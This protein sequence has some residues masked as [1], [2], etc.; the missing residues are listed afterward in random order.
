MEMD[1]NY[2]PLAPIRLYRANGLVIPFGLGASTD[3]QRGTALMQADA[4]SVAAGTTAT[5]KIVLAGDGFDTGATRPALSITSLFGAGIGKT[6]LTSDYDDATDPAFK[7]PANFIGQDFT[8][9]LTGHTYYTAGW[10]AS[11]TPVTNVRF[12]R[13]QVLGSDNDMFVFGGASPSATARW[14]WDEC[15]LTGPWDSIAT[16]RGANSYFYFRNSRLTAT[17][18]GLSVLNLFNGGKHYFDN[19]HLVNTAGTDYA[20]GDQPTVLIEGASVEAHFWGGSITNLGT[21]GVIGT[22]LQPN[23]GA[24]YASVDCDL[25]LTRCAGNAIQWKRHMGETARSPYELTLAAEM[26]S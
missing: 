19:C 2:E 17:T 22:S 8:I 14:Y 20:G 23:A 9:D 10:G 7:F 4:A 11:E 15:E 13:I 25:D 5:D 24:V 3:V 12:Y 6:V 16:N 1:L 21:G 26:Y 18:A